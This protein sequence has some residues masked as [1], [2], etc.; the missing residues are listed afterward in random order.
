MNQKMF[1][2]GMENN[3]SENEAKILS[4]HAILTR[5]GLL[6]DVVSM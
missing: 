4:D 2:A 1:K 3:V 6:I 5:E